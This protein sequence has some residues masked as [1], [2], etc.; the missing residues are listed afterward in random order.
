MDRNRNAALAAVLSLAVASC[1][2]AQRT[3]HPP[4]VT[5]SAG[6]RIVTNVL[7]TTA[8]ATVAQTPTVEIGG[9]GEP[10]AEL[11]MVVGAVRL[12]DGRIAIAEQSV[13]SIKIFDAQ[14]RFVRA[15]GRQ[16]AGPG[17][18]SSL[19][20]LDLLAGDSLAAYDG[21]RATLTVFDTTGR[22]ARIERLAAGPGGFKLE[23]LLGD[24]TMVLSR[25]YNLRFGR[26]S[27][28]ERDPITYV[29]V[30]PQSSTADTIVQVPGSDVYLFAG[31]DFS[32]RRELPFGRVSAIAVGRD[33]LFTG[34]GDSWQIETRAP[35]GRLV[36]FHRVRHAPAGVTK[37]EIARYKREYM[38]RIKGVRVQATGGG[39]DRPDMRS[40][41]VAQAERMLESVPYPETHA[42]YDSLLTGQ[43]A[44]L[45]VRR[46][47]PA[48]GEPS[49][50]TV[51]GRDGAASGTVTLPAG[52]RL[53]H[54][55][56]DF[57]V[58]MT[59]DSDDV[60]HVAVYPLR[61][62]PAGVKR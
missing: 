5:D 28:L 55:G 27:R 58:G 18:F 21:L 38:E 3:A 45:W 40:A 17:E 60:E 42:P 50:W 33:R 25:A 24:G 39:G 22:V 15:M 13:R 20:R 1:A 61:R 37:P 44:E 46:A 34:T 23:G 32:S 51:L 2:D 6:I 10:A 9:G 47:H 36:A 62:T 35:D 43:D 41:M 7:P 59:R 29:A 30:R 12:G 31:E 57:I 16:G 11:S 8:A 49:T 53:F 26:T 52:M 48:S 4:T 14:G 19:T 56:A 54:M